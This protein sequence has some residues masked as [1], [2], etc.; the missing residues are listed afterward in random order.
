MVDL[1][2]VVLESA[3]CMQLNS[4]SIFLHKILLTQQIK[5]VALNL[6]KKIIKCLVFCIGFNAVDN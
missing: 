6:C 2:D 1:L 4:K 3:A 5:L